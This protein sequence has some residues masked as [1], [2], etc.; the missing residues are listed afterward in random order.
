MFSD[1]MLDAFVQKNKQGTG[2]VPSDPVMF[3]D[4]EQPEAVCCIGPFVLSKYAL[5]VNHT[6][7]MF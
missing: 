5:C 3:T 4:E 2:S 6:C 1:K 7:T